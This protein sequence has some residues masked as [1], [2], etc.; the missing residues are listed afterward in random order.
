MLTIRF[1]PQKINEG[2]WKWADL[3]IFMLKIFFFFVDLNMGKVTT[4]EK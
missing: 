4:R 1:G 2:E 3:F